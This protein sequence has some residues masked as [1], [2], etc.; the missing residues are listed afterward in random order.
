MG[1]NDRNRKGGKQRFMKGTW[2]WEYMIRKQSQGAKRIE[3]A[4]NPIV[5]GHWKTRA[6]VYKPVHACNPSYSGGRSRRIQV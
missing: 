3:P 1:R 6:L 5:A 4:I 2:S